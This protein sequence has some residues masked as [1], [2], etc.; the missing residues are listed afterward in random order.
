MR[1][2]I[3]TNVLLAATMKELPNHS[4][5]RDF[6]EGVLS[7][8]NPWCL[9]WVNVYEY[10]RVITHP[11]VFKRPL[12]WSEAKTQADTLLS[13]PYLDILIETNRHLKALE[14]ATL[15]AGSVSGNFVHDCHVAALMLEHDVR[16]IVTYD[17]HFRRFP[18]IEAVFPEDL[19]I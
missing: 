17:T 18:D 14:K 10:L 1:F 12:K 16:R 19:T 3:D 5:S 15:G 8:D 2:L 4:K 11:R 13:H 9:S 7:S 6:V